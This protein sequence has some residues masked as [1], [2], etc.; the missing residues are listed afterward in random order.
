MVE[1]P[2]YLKAVNKM[3][4]LT[5]YFNPKYILRKK[6][7]LG[8]L[9]DTKS[10]LAQFFKVAWPS[11]LESILI[12]LVAFIDTQM[13]S[14]IG[15]ESVAAVGVT[16]QPRM[17]FYAVF[18]AINIG[19]TA[20]VSRR[21]GQED[22]EGARNCLA[23]SVSLTA[24]LGVV[25]CSVAIAFAEP[26][27]GLAGA[28][29]DIIGDSALYFRITMAG[30]LFTSIGMT[31]NAAHRGTGRTRISMVTNITANL[32]NCLLNY[33]LISENFLNG[34]L[35]ISPIGIKGAAVATLI[36]NVVSC[37]MSVW[38]VF[39]DKSSVLHIKL[40]ECFVIRKDILKL[41]ASVS[42]NAAI[43]QIFLRI[44]FFLTALMVN[45]LGTPSISTNTICMSI[46]TLSFCLGD[47]LGVGTSAL[48]G[49]NL[50]RKRKDLSLLY[51]SI[52]QRVGAIFSAMFMVLFFV[53]GTNMVGWFI[54]ENDPNAEF[55]MNAAEYIMILL[56]LT[57]PAQI[58]MVVY[59]GCLRGAG[60][61]FFVAISS[62]LS[63]AIVRPLFTY[64]FA[65]PLEFGVVGAYGAL[66]VDHYFRL[67]ICWIRFKGEKWAKIKI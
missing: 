50:G 20:I 48:V 35:N 21:T 26:L 14:V 52:G 24:L 58:S 55:I 43:E 46:L 23:Q 63:I 44:G 22:M 4:F 7:V 12:S 64:I 67:F 34:A 66:L 40:K 56:A 25:L 9:P 45:E 3:N 31:I 42:R 32:V 8:E 47:G 37:L 33:I 57:M 62:L 27:V 49:M 60:D 59:T 39:F 53:Y 51:G 38:T 41:H 5:G 61:T 15:T 1:Y 29:K 13:V 30:M 6:E 18:F 11:M 54:P 2:R 65:Y 10:A 36:G 28:D 17:I 16:G 19:V